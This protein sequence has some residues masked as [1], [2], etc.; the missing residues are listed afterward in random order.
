[1]VVFDDVASDERLKILERGAS[2]DAPAEEA[3][4]QSFGE[5]RAVLREGTITIPRLPNREPLSTQFEE[6]LAAIREGREPYSGIA[7]GP[8]R[9]ARARGRTA[10]AG[11]R[12]RARSAQPGAACAG[13]LSRAPRCDAAS[14]SSRRIASA[15]C[16]AARRSVP[17]RSRARSPSDATSRSPRPAPSRRPGS[18]PARA[19]RPRRP[20]P[21]APALPRGRR[22][23]H[24]PDQPARRG[25]LR[26]SKARIVYDLCD[27]LPLDILEAQA[28]ASREQQLLWST[29]SRSTTSS[30]RC[31][32]ATTSSAAATA[33]AT[34]TSARCSRRA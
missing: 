29:L 9:R 4:G 34:S 12:R 19:V 13:R 26:A 33:S 1:M 24:A 15:R 25:W 23:D 14:W 30:R 21:A 16:S 5:Y 11:E 10:L 6:F 8:R 7:A 20:A 22:G 17:T 28:S 32:P 3:R 2:Y 31:T 18:G 27:P